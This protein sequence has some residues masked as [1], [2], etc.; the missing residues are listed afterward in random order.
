MK[1]IQ[2]QTLNV[3]EIIDKITGKYIKLTYTL[4]TTSRVSRDFM[5]ETIFNN[6]NNKVKSHSQ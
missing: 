5:G 3:T 6:L 2:N 4:I 1:S